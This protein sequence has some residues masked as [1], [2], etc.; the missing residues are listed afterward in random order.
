MEIQAN[1]IIPFAYTREIEEKLSDFSSKYSYKYGKCWISIQSP[2]Y[3]FMWSLF[4][5]KEW[6]KRNSRGEYEPLRITY[7]RVYEA[8]EYNDAGFLT[9][10]LSGDNCFCIEDEYSYYELVNG[11]YIQ[12]KPFTIKG[13]SKYDIEGINPVGELIITDKVKFALERESLTGV[14]YLPIFKDKERNKIIEGYWQLHA[15]NVLSPM[16]QYTEIMVDSGERPQQFLK[17]QLTY[18][19]NLLKDLKDFNVTSEL[20]GSGRKGVQF[21]VISNPVYQL[22]KEFK[23]CPVFEPIRFV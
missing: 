16:S 15:T 21:K 5:Q 7:R 22:L 23:I 17:S 20:W 10:S 12:V 8:N 2:E 6:L 18:S 19:K 14:E 4:E 1:F 9:M 11:T 3:N 13:K